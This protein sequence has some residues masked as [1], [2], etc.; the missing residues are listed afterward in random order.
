MAIETTCSG[1]GKKLAVPAEHAGKQA[2]CPVCGQI[3]TVP[4]PATEVTG[5][6]S[7][8]P[9]TRAVDRPP[10]TVASGLGGG[11]AS[12][13]QASSDPSQFWMEATD[14]NVYGPVDRPGLDRWFRE[15]RVGPG[16]RIRQGEYGNWANA[17]EFR[18][19]EQSSV[20]PYAPT[21]ATPM[22]GTGLFN[23]PK[24]DNG[25]LVLAMGILGFIVCPIFSI[26]AWIMGAGA[27]RDI[28]DGQMDPKNKGL[29]QAG[30]YLGIINCVLSLFCIGAYFVIIALSVVA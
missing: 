3:Y 5:G 16:Y 27:L 25:V 28:A 7:P 11:P 22:A 20:N 2:R 9:N 24:A 18:P 10:E 12:N 30:Y 17:E 23:Y 13:P 4:F 29:V 26:V 6:A 8:P 19:R 21:Q 15:G 14:G 1:C